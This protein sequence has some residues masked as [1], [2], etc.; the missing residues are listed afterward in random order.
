MQVTSNKIYIDYLD[1]TVSVQNNPVPPALRLRFDLLL[2]SQ[3]TLCM[4]VPACVKLKTTTDLLMK[5]TPF[6]KAGKIRLILDRKHRNNPWNY[7]SNRNRVLERGFPEEQLLHHFE[8]NAYHSPHTQLFYNSF[9]HEVIQYQNDSFIGKIFDTDEM[10]RRSVIEQSKSACDR[11]CSVL[12]VYQAIHMGK[13]LN[14]L[15][16]IAEDRSHLFQRSAIETNLITLHHANKLEI[17][18][19]K[20]I[21]DKGFAYANGIS[22]YAAPLSQ[23]TNRLTSLTFIPVLKKADQ[24]LYNMICSLSWT[25]LYKLSTNDLWLD[26]VDQVNRLL[27]LYQDSKRRSQTLLPPSFLGIGMRISNLAEG[28]YEAAAESLQQELIKNGVP[29]PEVIRTR[30]YGESM[31]EMIIRNKHEYWLLVKEIDAKLSA[32][33]VYI[34]SLS[35]RYKDKI[36]RLDREGFIITTDND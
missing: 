33:K 9:F 19:I 1:Y 25:A 22:S 18:V 11:L 3:D 29:F 23:I 31:L 21:L 26:F 35:R 32:I 28:L 7:F 5:L 4:S 8:Y 10:F 36:E 2:Y 13:I 6:W 15:I 24:E 17:D 30:E 20:R 12:P 14:D 27:L 16:I 34:R